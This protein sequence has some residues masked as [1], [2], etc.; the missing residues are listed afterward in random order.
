[1]ELGRIVHDKEDVTGTLGEGKNQRET[2]ETK[3]KEMEG[4]KS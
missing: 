4:V 3:Q 1:M 2:K